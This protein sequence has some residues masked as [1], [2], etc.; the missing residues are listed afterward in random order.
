MKTK[1]KKETLSIR[2]PVELNK[3]FTKYITSLGMSKNA[4]IISLI[5]KELEKQKDINLDCEVR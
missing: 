5:I 2:L 1:I 4:F 3:K